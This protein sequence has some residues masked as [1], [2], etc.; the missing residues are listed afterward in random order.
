[1]SRRVKDEEEFVWNDKLLETDKF[2][3]DD[4]WQRIAKLFR[5]CSRARA[6]QKKRVDAT[7]AY[8]ELVEA[9]LKM[10]V[11]K[12]PEKYDT[13][14]T[15]KAVENCVITLPEYQ[16]A[17]KDWIES[18]YKL[19]LLDGICDSVQI[20]RRALED[21][22]TLQGRDYWAD[23]RVRGDNKDLKEKYDELEKRSLRRRK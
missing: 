7:K 1:M 3:L 16:E 13:K 6:K 4:E 11:Y 5:N 15:D 12:D 18:K 21:L 22:V 9:K 19:D 20:K 10:K 17:Q 14:S 23:P 2:A 8:F